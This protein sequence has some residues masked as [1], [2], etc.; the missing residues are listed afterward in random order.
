LLGLFEQ[1]L[2][3]DLLVG[4]QRSHVRREHPGQPPTNITHTAVLERDL[5]MGGVS[6]RP[7][8]CPSDVGI[9]L[10]LIT[11]GLI[12]RFSPLSSRWKDCYTVLSAT[13]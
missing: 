8:V 3:A 5:A 2:E 10:K 6:V 9:E 12:T 7:S 11:V 1:E 4:S 13:C